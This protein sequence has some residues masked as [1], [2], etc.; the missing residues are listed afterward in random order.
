MEHTN[1][2]TPKLIT[3]EDVPTT[4]PVE[5]HVASEPHDMIQLPESLKPVSDETAHDLGEVALSPASGGR[6]G[7]GVIPI[8][9]PGPMAIRQAVQNGSFPAENVRR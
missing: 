6:F 3:V 1:T 5:V 2:N 4:T 8:E 9:N 7:N